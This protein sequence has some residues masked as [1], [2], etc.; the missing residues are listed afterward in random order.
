MHDEIIRN[1]YLQKIKRNG[2]WIWVDRKTGKEI[3]PI[4]R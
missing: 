2:K 4:F 3:R 1:F